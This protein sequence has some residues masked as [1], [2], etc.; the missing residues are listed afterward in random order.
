MSPRRW[1]ILLVRERG[2]MAAVLLLKAVI[3]KRRRLRMR[4]KKVVDCCIMIERRIG[5]RVVGIGILVRDMRREGVMRD[6]RVIEI[7][8]L[9]IEGVRI[10]GVRRGKIDGFFALCLGSSVV[11]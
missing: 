8:D 4:M 5:Q 1:A 3:R 6:D 9:A 11:R 2:K 10:R 7:E